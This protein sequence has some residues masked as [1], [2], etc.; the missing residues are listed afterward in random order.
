MTAL[1]REGPGLP[2]LQEFINAAVD[3]ACAVDAKKD[4]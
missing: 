4:G 2:K 1:R 3:F